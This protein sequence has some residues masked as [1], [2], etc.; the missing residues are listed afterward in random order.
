[1]ELY[2]FKNALTTLC[3]FYERKEPKPQSIVLWFE[4]VKNIPSEPVPWM[5]KKIEDTNDS[6]PKN[7]PGSFWA[8]F[9]EWKQA[10]PEK[11]A[12]KNY[13]HCPDCD[14]GLL[15]VIKND[16]RGK[17]VFRCARCRQDETRAYPF[18]N[19][20]DLLEEYTFR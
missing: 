1:M 9:N 3:D 12:F 19:R 17:Y 6:F 20:K 7:M 14:E 18:A 4:A 10:H 15:L 16:T 2:E 13:F 11:R 5:V 8:T